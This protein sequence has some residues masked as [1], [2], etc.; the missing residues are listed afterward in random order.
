QRVALLLQ[1]ARA[2]VPVRVPDYSALEW[3]FRFRD[4]VRPPVIAI[5]GAADRDANHVVSPPSAMINREIRPSAHQIDVNL[6]C[7]DGVPF[8]SVPCF[9]GRTEAVDFLECHYSVLMP[10]RSPHPPHA[11]MDEEILVVMNGEA[12]LVVLASPGDASPNI[13]PAP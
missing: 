11:H 5:A 6:R 2:D 9:F 13:F 10:G 8:E 1:F 7:K 3:P 12:E 4:D